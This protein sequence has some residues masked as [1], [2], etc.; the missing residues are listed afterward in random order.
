MEVHLAWRPGF[1]G[2]S[3][4]E[5]ALMTRIATTHVGSLPRSRRALDFLFARD[6]GE[7]YDPADFAACMAGGAAMASERI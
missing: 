4:E 7:P 2:R 1:P 6:R 5:E 3:D